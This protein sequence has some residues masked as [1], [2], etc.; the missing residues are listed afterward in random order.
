M[1]SFDGQQHSWKISE[2]C[3]CVILSISCHYPVWGV[4]NYRLW[5]CQG[6]CCACCVSPAAMQRLK[7]H[8]IHICIHNSTSASSE[9]PRCGF[10]CEKH[11]TCSSQMQFGFCKSREHRK[12]KNMDRMI[13]QLSEWEKYAPSNQDFKGWR[14]ES[15]QTAEV[16]SDRVSDIFWLIRPMVPW[17]ASESTPHRQTRPV[18][19][20]AP[21]CQPQPIRH[22]VFHWQRMPAVVSD[23]HVHL[24][25][26]P[27][28]IQASQCQGS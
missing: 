17:W 11:Q 7:E 14:N 22:S 16:N 4:F 6:P 3:S 25:S 26:S 20:K 23:P 2:T 5:C 21:L 19:T 18:C 9:A 13:D 15:W 27:W 28:N 24:F 1:K 8:F 10:W 12:C